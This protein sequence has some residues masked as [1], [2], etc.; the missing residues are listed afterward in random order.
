LAG[1]CVA[2]Q[3][4]AAAEVDSGERIEPDVDDVGRLPLPG[5]HYGVTATERA[6]FDPRPGEVERDPGARLGLVELVMGGLDGA[7]ARPPGER[8]DL[9]RLVDV[10]RAADKGPRHDRPRSLGREHTVDPHTGSVVVD[11]AWRG[12][13]YVVQR[14]AHAVEPAAR[15]RVAH[16]D[17][18]TGEGGAGE[19]GGDPG[20]GALAGGGRPEVGLS[21]APEAAAPAGH[22]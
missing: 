19:A 10:Q 6:P 17:R 18:R 20:P 8:A 16:D 11:G 4:R 1:A 2:L 15:E 5:P 13:E 9:A 12:R 3:R 7:D 22:A 21:H 14:A